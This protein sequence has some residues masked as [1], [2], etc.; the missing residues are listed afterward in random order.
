MKITDF[1]QLKSQ[2]RVC[3]EFI[4]NEDESFTAIKESAC[5]FG[6]GYRVKVYPIDEDKCRMLIVASINFERKMNELG[7][8]VIQYPESESG[9]MIGQWN[10]GKGESYLDF[11]SKDIHRVAEMLKVK[12]VKNAINPYSVR[13]VNLF[14]RFQRNIHPRYAEILEKRLEE[15]SEES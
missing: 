14:L 3:C 9:E 12:K 1:E 11:W 5:M 7:I 10:N 8:E 4:Y 6:H 15:D 13:G 2:Y